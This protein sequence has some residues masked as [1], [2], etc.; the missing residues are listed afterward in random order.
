M[1]P[2]RL[3]VQRGI[4]DDPLSRA[5]QAQLAQAG[6]AAA[7]RSRTGAAAPETVPVADS[8]ELEVRRL[9]RDW[10]RACAH[11]ADVTAAELRPDA[12]FGPAR[13]AGTRPVYP[14]VS[15]Q[16]SLDD[17]DAGA[18]GRKAKLIALA[19]AVLTPSVLTEETAACLEAS[20]LTHGA[21][22]QAGMSRAPPLRAGASV[23][24][25]R[26]RHRAHDRATG[27]ITADDWL[28]QDDAED[29]LLEK[30]VVSSAA[31]TGRPGASLL[32]RDGELV[33]L[34]TA[35]AGRARVA[36]SLMPGSRGRAALERMLA[37]AR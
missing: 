28:Q 4:E 8:V 30:L 33:G 27:A 15:P 16:S 13:D 29:P 25:I 11:V 6:A 20:H 24:A 23:D 9:D 37:Q 35:G 12:V 36:V 22:A 31:R 7:A 21:G 1:P 14:L 18:G 5:V 2:A 10:D 34:V 17:A 19:D 3:Q 26:W 32:S